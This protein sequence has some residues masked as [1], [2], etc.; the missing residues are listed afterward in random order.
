MNKASILIVL[1]ILLG[2]RDKLTLISENTLI[3]KIIAEELPEPDSLAIIDPHGNTIS[4]D[5]LKELELTG[6]YFE[7]F[8]V[9]KRNEITELRVRLKTDDDDIFLAKVSQKLNPEREV[10][11]IEIDC[12]KQVDLLHQVYELDQGIRTGGSS[13]DP[14]V[15]HKNLEIIV[16]LLESCGMP[17]ID[18]V[19]QRGMDAIWLVLQHAPPTYQSK[20]I[21]QLEL[22]ADRGDL[23][24]SVIALMKDRALMHEGKPQIYGSQ[25]R[26][27]ELYLL[28]EPGLVNSRRESVGLEPIEEYLEKFGIKFDIDQMER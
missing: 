20:Y 27:G 13:V 26:N 16:N 21:P 15:D 14:D 9:N 11:K 23:P 6:R 5:S 1:V 3:E 17:T 18:Q 10:R 25:I 19:A 24:K 12:Q 2:C 28:F 7:D 4:V 8:Y 22:A